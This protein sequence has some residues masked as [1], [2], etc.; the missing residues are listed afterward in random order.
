MVCQGAV[1]EIKS[2]RSLV[3]LPDSTVSIQT[4]SRVAQNLANSALSSNFA[5]WAKP[6]VQ[7]K[8]EAIGFVEV[9]LPA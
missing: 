9:A 7:A 1:L 3:I 4:R 8:I 2:A 6:W 5:R